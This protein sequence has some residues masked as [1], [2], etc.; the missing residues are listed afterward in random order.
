M[1][2]GELQGGQSYGGGLKNYLMHF[3]LDQVAGEHGNQLQRYNQFLGAGE[4]TYVDWHN[5]LND[6][7]IL[8]GAE[9]PGLRREEPH[10]LQTGN[11]RYIVSLAELP[12][13]L[14][15]RGRR[16]LVYEVPGAL[17]RAYLV[18]GVRVVENADEALSA[19]G[20]ADFDP[21]S[22]AVVDRP[23]AAPLS[24][25][26]VSGQAAVDAYGPDRVVVR[27]RAE[28]DALLVLADNYYRNWRVSIDGETAPLV[29]ANHTFRGVRVP[30]GEHEVVF[31]FHPSD[32]YLGLWISVLAIILALS[33]VAWALVRLRT[34][35]GAAAPVAS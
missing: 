3:R 35:A 9:T 25:G 13:P 20:S 18:G 33:P 19:I 2:P 6:L 30:A 12:L 8:V 32:V 4:R 17:P 28:Q 29:R 7:R 16:G 11:I 15:H 21:L 26:R 23:L 1:L 22:E 5:V 14:V 24:G 31:E 10:F 27:S 34:R